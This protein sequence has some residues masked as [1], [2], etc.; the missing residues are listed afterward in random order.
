MKLKVRTVELYA[1]FPTVLLNPSLQFKLGIHEGGRLKIERDGRWIVATTYLSNDISSLNIGIPKILQGELKVKPGQYVEVNY[2][3]PPKSV[4]YIRSRLKGAKLGKE[5]YLEIV[6][7][8]VGGSL[9]DVELTAFILSQYSNRMSLEEVKYLT[10]AMVS[11]GVKVD[12]NR[13]VYD[14]HSIGGVPGNKVTLLIVPIIAAAGLL[15][16]KTSSRAITSPSGTADTMEVLADVEFTPNEFKEIAQKV[17]GCI[18]W[19]GKLGFSPADDIIISRVE[20]PLDI[21]P[22]S[23]MLASILSKKLAV[24]ADF[25]VIDIPTGKGAKVETLDEARDLSAKFTELG[26]MLG[27][28]I[29]CGVTYGSQP[30]GHAIGPALEAKEALEALMGGGPHSLKE[31]STALAGILLE[32]AGLASRGNGKDVA[33]ELLNSGKAL[34]KMREIIEAQGGDPNVK[35]EDLPI[36]EYKATLYA[37]CDGYIAEVSNFAVSAVA[38]AAGAPTDKGA[39]VLLKGKRGYVVEKGD[40]IMEIYAEYESKLEVAY[41]LALKLQPVTVEGMLLHRFPDSI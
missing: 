29:I 31:K 7:S 38:K 35:P 30:V 26:R 37:P 40:P 13:P 34:Q 8:I 4:D 20:H 18:I 10:E 5:E 3:P 16:P 21:D 25:L 17:G 39:G 41:N 11:T 15:I 14:K 32:M 2:T 19:G 22:E 33:D 1:K 24:G 27:I 12:F 28:R 6:R 9:T 23:Q 36:G